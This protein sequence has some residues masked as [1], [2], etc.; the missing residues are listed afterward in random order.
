MYQK[1]I[2]EEDVQAEEIEEKKY[3]SQL[4][5]MILFDHF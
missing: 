5:K 2:E 4:R 1:N 3:S